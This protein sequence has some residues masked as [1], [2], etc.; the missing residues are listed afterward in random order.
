MPSGVNKDFHAFQQMIRVFVN[1]HVA[2]F[3]DHLL[4]PSSLGQ[5]VYHAKSC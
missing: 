2:M 5:L 1:P 3:S 4:E